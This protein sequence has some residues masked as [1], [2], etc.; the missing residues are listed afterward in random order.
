MR[1][2]TANGSS[3]G[4]RVAPL[5]RGTV[6][7]LSHW[8]TVAA[9]R[10]M[11]MSTDLAHV[12]VTAAQ[13]MV[14]SARGLQATLDIMSKLVDFRCLPKGMQP[15]EGMLCASMGHKFG[16]N[17]LEACQRFHVIN[18]TLSMKADVMVGVAKAHPAC[19]Y[20]RCVESTDER[21][22]FET[23]RD[24]TPAPERESFTM[25]D[26]KRAGLLSNKMWGKYP[27][28]MLRARCSAG[29]ARLVYSDILAGIYTAD[30]LGRPEVE[31]G[32]IIDAPYTATPQRDP[33]R[34]PQRQVEQD[35]PGDV[36]D[37][38]VAFIKAGE[39][40]AAVETYWAARSPDSAKRVN[41]DAIAKWKQDAAQTFGD[42]L[43]S[44]LAAGRDGI[45]PD[46]TKALGRDV[47]DDEL[48]ALGDR[49]RWAAESELTAREYAV[50]CAL[51][52]R[53]CVEKPETLHLR[54]GLPKVEQGEGG[55]A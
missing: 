18:G 52:A 21:A 14:E 5:P 45:R 19:L 22:T 20:F 29:L 55:E 31:M 35:A 50:A 41:I 28:Q 13:Q 33:S 27:R 6:A 10:R 51:L 38:L 3:E 4:H 54:L 34:P 44:V 24:G 30:E 7:D 36:R 40:A 42:M 43:H 48:R 46:M 32:D 2:A 23:H 26:A 47:T 9:V 53:R 37:E 25:A 39:I 17:P 49:V 12:G 15:G 16:W 8:S 1:W 11:S